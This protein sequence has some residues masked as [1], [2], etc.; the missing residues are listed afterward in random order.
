M[1]PTPLIRNKDKKTTIRIM[2][3]ER[4]MLRTLYFFMITPPHSHLSHFSNITS[5]LCRLQE[6]FLSEEE[7]NCHFTYLYYLY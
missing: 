1:P 3:K 5:F 7:Q 6:T 2:V 4:D